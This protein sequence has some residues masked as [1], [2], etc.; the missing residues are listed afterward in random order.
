[1]LL[2]KAFLSYS[3][4]DKQLAGRVKEQLS[5]F[6]ID[7]FLAHED[8]SPSLEWQ[9]EII[10]QVEACDVFITLH[11]GSFKLSDWTDQESGMAIV[12]DKVIM[13]VHVT[14]GPHGF[15]S[16]YQAHPLDASE[17]GLSK[18]CKSIVLAIRD[19]AELRTKFQNSFIQDFI[20]SENFND[21][22]SK[23]ESLEEF[24]PY[25]TDQIE[26]IVCGA[27]VNRQIYEAGAASRRLKRLYSR[28]KDSINP[29]LGKQFEERFEVS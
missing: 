28:Y 24:G 4:D 9:G 8:L 11:T 3:T 27:I 22:N 6:G 10:K 13:P 23:S 7:V 1:M 19:R 5:Y 12:K 20:D 17:I 16:R 26:H 29:D 15:L 2:L 25:S 21:A 18:S 14:R